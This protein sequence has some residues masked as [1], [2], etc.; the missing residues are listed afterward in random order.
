MANKKN[1]NDEKEAAEKIKSNVKIV[2]RNLLKKI[3]QNI[4]MIA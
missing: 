1:K 3:T 4:V 2:E